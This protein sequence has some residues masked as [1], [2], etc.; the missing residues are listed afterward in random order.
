[1]YAKR[2][3][4]FTLV[5]LLVVIAI[6]GILVALLLPAIQA[7]REAARRTSCINNVRQIVLGIHNYELAYDHLPV[8]TTN[9]TGPIN[10]LPDG[11]HISWLARTLPYIGEQNRAAHL[12]PQLSAYHQA[13]DT[14]RQTTIELLICPSYGGMDSAASNYAGCHHDREAPIDEDNNGAFVLN[15]RIHLEDLKDGASYTFLIGEKL[16]D[17]YDLGW[18]SG[19]SA[20]LR[21]TGFAPNTTINGGSNSWSEYSTPDELPWATSGGYGMDYWGESDLDETDE[22]WDADTF[23]E[24]E[25][26]FDEDFDGDESA[27]DGNRTEGDAGEAAD[28]ETKPNKELSEE[29][30]DAGAMPP[31]VDQE[32]LQEDSDDMEREVAPGFLARSLLGGNPQAPKRVGGFAGQHS[33]VVVFGLADGAVDTIGEDIDVRAYRQMANRHDGE[34]PEGDRW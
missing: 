6:I 26:V 1:M 16:P 4:A 13:N 30:K 11:H 3:S 31:E 17:D 20:T 33:G 10:N 29:E 14:V 34:I 8:G 18:L 24:G 21:N 25:I 32:Q 22:E 5:E 15:R 28:D 12:D 19:T 23:V 9:K 7:A 27:E 2:R